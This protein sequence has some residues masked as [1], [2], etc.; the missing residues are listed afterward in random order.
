MLSAI[1][2]ESSSLTL[3]AEREFLKALGGGCQ[4]PVAAYAQIE[5]ANIRISAM[6]AVPDGSRIFRTE[7]INA[8]DDP[9]FAG[10]QAAK[11]LLDTGGK[12]IIYKN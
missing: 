3:Q 4:V 7:T 9:L 10:R 8:V 12:A 11:V 2:D 5:S 1:N 6:A